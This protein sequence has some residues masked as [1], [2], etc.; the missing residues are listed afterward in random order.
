[1]TPA[2]EKTPIGMQYVIPGAERIVK[3]R[4][5][6]FMRSVMRYTHGAEDRQRSA[7]A[8][9]DF[10]EATPVKPVRARPIL[11]RKDAS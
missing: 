8:G 2:I 11:K 7:L 3:P 4:R 9:I 5:R 1:M 6:E 10:G